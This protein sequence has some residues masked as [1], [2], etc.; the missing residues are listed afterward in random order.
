MKKESKYKV[1]E[2]IPT[3][4]GLY[5]KVMTIIDGYVMCRRKGCIPFGLTIDDFESMLLIQ[6]IKPLKNDTPTSTNN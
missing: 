2:K 1:G 5:V 4:D 3:N 6:A